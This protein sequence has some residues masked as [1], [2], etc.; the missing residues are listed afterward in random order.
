MSSLSL[1]GKRKKE[2]KN[3]NERQRDR[4]RKIRKERGRRK[5]L[6]QISDTFDCKVFGITAAGVEGDVTVAQVEGDVI[7]PTKHYRAMVHPT[8]KPGLHLL[9]FFAFC[10]QALTC[11]RFKYVK[12]ALGYF[13]AISTLPVCRSFICPYW[14]IFGLNRFVDRIVC[15]KIFSRWIFK[16][17]TNSTISNPA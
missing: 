10:A 5:N 14:S 16:K 3:K 4:Q 11:R 2:R 7:A 9:N 17:S 6:Y 1:R 12:I 15:I 8:T 13:K